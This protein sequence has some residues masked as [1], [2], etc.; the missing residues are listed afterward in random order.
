LVWR[1][2][3]LYF[4]LRIKFVL[5]L[6]LCPEGDAKKFI[7]AGDNTYGG[8]VVV[9]PSGGLLAKGHPLGATGLAQ[10]SELVWQMRGEAGKRQV[11]NA[12]VGMQHNLGL[13]SAIVCTLYKLGR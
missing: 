10:C 2:Q 13:G 7:D 11:E 8:K 5:P 12:K 6:Q 9:N 1:I 3:N 4:S